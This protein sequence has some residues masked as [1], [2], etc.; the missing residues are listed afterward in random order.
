MVSDTWLSADAVTSLAFVLA[1]SGV[2]V[3]GRAGRS[4]WTYGILIAAT[5]I[6]SV[7]QHGPDPGWA[8][9]AHDLP[10]VA[11]LAYLA[12]DAAADVTGRRLDARW[13]TVPTLVLL[14]LI[15]VAPL[16]ADAAQGAMAA[17]AVGLSLRRAW[18][19]PGT[20]ATI[21]VAM[22]LLAVG[23]AIGT[24]TR[25]GMPLRELAVPV[26]GH[27]IWHVLAAAALWWLAA[28]VGRRDRGDD[29]AADP[30]SGGRRSV[31]HH[32]GSTGW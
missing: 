2:V 24:S 25:P 22:S 21:L 32:T 28:V 10:I 12:V 17:V 20:R 16:A 1:G 8:D 26:P 30:G 6:G 11:L 7:I 15:V 18:L 4:S 14:P 13:W 5:G 27:G 31:M 29:V 3:A 9:L 23:G 19:R